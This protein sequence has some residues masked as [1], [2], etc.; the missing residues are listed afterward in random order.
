MRYPY[1]CRVTPDVQEPCPATTQ[2]GR[3]AN[4]EE[5]LVRPTGLEP[6]ALSFEG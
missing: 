6:V 4:N 5:R 2:E 1:S 3:P